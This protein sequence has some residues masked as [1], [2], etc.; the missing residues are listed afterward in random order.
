M[1]LSDSTW[2]I[3][4]PEPLDSVIRGALLNALAFA[5]GDQRT[6]AKLLGV[7]ARVMLYQMV[8]HDIPTDQGAP[9]TR[10]TIK[11]LTSRHL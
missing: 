1:Q 11:A 4:Q 10:A 3:Y 8:K 2:L 6:A 5:D 9:A 7:S